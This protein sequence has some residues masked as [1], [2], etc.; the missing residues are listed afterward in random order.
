MI[1]RATRLERVA[2]RGKPPTR[3]GFA[4]PGLNGSSLVE[5]T[6]LP[7][8]ASKEWETPFSS[9]DTSPWLKSARR[10][11]HRRIPAAAKA[12]VAIHGRN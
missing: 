4:Q 9:F 2:W 6:I 11:S 10:L 5:E 1:V 8:H 7:V 3:A 12:F